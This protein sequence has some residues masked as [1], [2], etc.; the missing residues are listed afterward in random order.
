MQRGVEKTAIEG[1]GAELEMSLF[2]KE[3][4]SFTGDK[5]ALADSILDK[6]KS[7]IKV[8]GTEV[9]IKKVVLKNPKKAY[10]SENSVFKETISELNQAAYAKFTDKKKPC[11]YLSLDTAGLSGDLK[12]LVKKANKQLKKN[13]VKIDILPLNLTAGNIKV[14]KINEK[15]KEVKKAYISDE[16]GN[17]TKLKANAS[18]KKDIMSEADGETIVIHGTNNYNGRVRYYP[19]E[20]TF[21]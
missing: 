6:E 16:N 17:I 12:K 3:A 21:K 8:N 5:K 14:E 9:K 19:A 11:Y 1:T 7:V 4:L 18:G 15:K 10:V 13:P 20:G 2:A